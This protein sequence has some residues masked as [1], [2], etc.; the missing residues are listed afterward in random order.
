[1]SSSLPFG[2]KQTITALVLSAFVASG[3]SATTSRVTEP[4]G[5][6]VNRTLKSD[7]LTQAPTNGQLWAPSISIRK[8]SQ[9][10]R[11][12]LGCDRNFSPLAQPELAHVFKRCMV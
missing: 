1:M 4:T 10:S 6:M 7:R 8:T 11:V 9:V 3:V 2:L 12:P 5:V